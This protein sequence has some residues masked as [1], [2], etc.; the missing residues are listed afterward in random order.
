MLK[1]TTDKLQHTSHR[2]G[3]S[4]SRNNIAVVTHHETLFV[5]L[6][7]ALRKR[8]ENK[9]IIDILYATVAAAEQ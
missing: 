1:W 8:W 6:T 5:K 2:S 4:Y 9:D 3:Y 7:Y